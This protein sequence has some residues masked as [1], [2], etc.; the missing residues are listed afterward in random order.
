M[1][2]VQL[3]DL[4]SVPEMNLLCNVLEY[5]YRNNI[6][7]HPQS[8]FW[9]VKESVQSIHPVMHQIVASNPKKY[10]EY[11]SLLRDYLVTLREQDK[12]VFLVTNSPYN[13]V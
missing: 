5:L 10:L 1:K 3:A 12:K 13:F 4:F 8:L 9:D 2:M 6:D 7:Y 11:D